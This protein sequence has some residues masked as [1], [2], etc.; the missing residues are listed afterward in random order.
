VAECTSL[1]MHDKLEWMGELAD[2]EGKLVCPRCAYRVGSYHWS[3]AQCSCG[4]QAP[5]SPPPQAPFF[6]STSAT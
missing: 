2:V 1:F 5:P 3:G 4:C 6:L